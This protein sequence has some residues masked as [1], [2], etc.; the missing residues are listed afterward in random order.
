VG[1]DEFW[2]SAGFTQ[3]AAGFAELL[4]NLEQALLDSGALWE[5]RSGEGEQSLADLAETAVVLSCGPLE[6]EGFNPSHGPRITG[7]LGLGAEPGKDGVHGDVGRPGFPQP[8]KR[9]GPAFRT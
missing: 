8:R 7:R 4:G 6:I 5:A 9:N 3:G 2:K 1:W